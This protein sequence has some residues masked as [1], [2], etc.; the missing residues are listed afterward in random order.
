MG[1]NLKLLQPCEISALQNPE[2]K[3][4]SFVK[5]SNQAEQGFKAAQH[6]GDGEQ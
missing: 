3:K 6:A 5:A 1:Q 2:R 4:K